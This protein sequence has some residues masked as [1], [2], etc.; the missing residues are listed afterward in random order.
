MHQIKQNIL[1]TLLQLKGSGKFASIGTA[2]FVFPGL[3]IEGMEEIAFPINSIQALALIGTAQKAPFGQGRSTIY[4]DNVRSAR[5]IDAAK[6]TFKNPAWEKLIKKVL[7]NVKAD[8]G[9][10]D[11]SIAANL[12]KLLI[13]K[14]GDFFLPHKD[15]EK[16]KGM[17]GSLV[18]G[19]PSSHTGGEL[20]IHFEGVKETADFARSADPYAINY[21]AFYADCDHEVKPLGAGCRVCLVYNLV[22]EKAGKKIALQSVQTHA[23]RLA[24]LL[25][26]H[27]AQEDP[28]PAIVLL[29]HQYTPENF[30]YDA[31]KLNDRAK[32]EALLQAAQKA[33]YYAR[34]C[35]VTSYLSG[36]PAYDG[37][38]DDEEDDSDAEMEEVYD[39]SL[40]I[41]H[42]TKSELPTPDNVPFEE[43]ELITSF[44]LD[45]GEPIIKESTGY[46]GNYGPDLMHWYH[47]GA[48]MIWS[49]DVNARLLLTQGA[50]SQLSWISYFNRTKQITAAEATSIEF[51]VST[52][53]NS[54]HRTEKEVNYNALADWLVNRNDKAFLLQLNTGLLQSYFIKIDPAKWVTIFNNIPADVTAGTFE[55]LTETITL[56]V[57]KQLVAVLQEMAGDK[58][59][60]SIAAAQT[61]DLPGYFKSVY[62]RDPGRVD[63]GTLHH[64]LWMAKK[65]SPVAAWI[66]EILP[67]LTKDLQRSYVHKVL[68]P[69]LL[70]VKDG[71]KL[72]DGLRQSC[73]DYLQQRADQQPQPP[74]DWS[75]PLPDT[76][77]YSKEWQLLKTFLESPTEQVFNFRKNQA[78]RTAL[79]HAIKNATIDL[80]T[81]TIKTGSPHTLRITKTQATY[82]RQM[83][84]WKEDVVLLEKL[85]K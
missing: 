26:Q 85:K 8:L 55:K 33:G 82:Q 3:T 39:D 44:A 7:T 67:I 2:D 28:R 46:M 4:D 51:I 78:E 45:E 49:P 31:L 69:L 14:E 19:L 18:I 65:A 21:A 32:A 76:K 37:Y 48:V 42:W 17:F 61:G 6:I 16:E 43:N 70:Q 56:P 74:P 64:L 29:G 5:E 47:Y 12:Y 15:T 52:G 23:A 63:A 73:R 41:E 13:Y 9:L 22:Q 60:H 79:E 50:A 10:E 80:K 68:A 53:F 27:Q 25:S 58:K 40:S 71:S 83:K 81:E 20:V 36:A 54:D 84:D 34:A 38:Y 24:E 57:L 72:T 66:Q 59:L 1:E 77:Q 62:S 30:S 11:Y 75:R 35:L